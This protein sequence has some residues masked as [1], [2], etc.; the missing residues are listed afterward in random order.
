MKQLELEFLY[1]HPVYKEY[2]GDEQGNVYSLDYN[3]TGKIMKLK[4][5][6]NKDGYL[7]FGCYKYSKKNTRPYVHRFIWE[8]IKGEIPDGYHVDHLDFDRENNCIDNLLARPARENRARLSEEGRRSRSEAVK[9]ALSK[10]VVQLD[11]QDNLIAEF[12]SVREAGI[13]TGVDYRYISACCKGK[14]HTAG[15]FKWKDKEVA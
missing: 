7:R 1:E 15:G 3:H 2:A 14:Q 5:S 13:Q 8:C 12:P 9:K 11:V 10:P 4:P 6:L